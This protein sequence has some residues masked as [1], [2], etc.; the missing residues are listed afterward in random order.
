MIKA[1][2]ARRKNRKGD[3]EGTLDLDPLDKDYE[4]SDMHDEDFLSQD[5]DEMD[6][7]L[8]GENETGNEDQEEARREAKARKQK[9]MSR[10]MK[11]VEM[12]HGD[13]NAPG[14]F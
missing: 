5:G 8:S 3:H 6:I 4:D 7:E 14:K 1:I 13:D 9:R 12:G 10:I 2:M 11:P